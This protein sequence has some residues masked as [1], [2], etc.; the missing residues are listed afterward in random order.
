[1]QAKDV[2]ST[3]NIQM[4]VFKYVWR[5]PQLSGR[6]HPAQMMTYELGQRIIPFSATCAQLR[7]HKLGLDLLYLAMNKRTWG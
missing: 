6:L 4:Q 2:I 3:L 1:L 5:I 7:I